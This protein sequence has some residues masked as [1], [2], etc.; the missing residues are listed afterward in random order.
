M[1]YWRSMGLSRLR[2]KRQMSLRTN[3][4]PAQPPRGLRT[5]GPN[6]RTPCVDLRRHHFVLAQQHRHSPNV[7]PRLQ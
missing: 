4:Q 3:P 1:H 6:L 7:H 2:A 5:R